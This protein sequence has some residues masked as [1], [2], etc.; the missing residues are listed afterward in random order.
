[1]YMTKGNID[2]QP[3]SSPL[4]DTQLPRSDGHVMT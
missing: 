1:M 4:G 2:G 3:E